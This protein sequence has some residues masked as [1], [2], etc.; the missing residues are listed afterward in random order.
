M[1]HDSKIS[2]R[3]H[4]TRQIYE[5]QTKHSWWSENRRFIAAIRTFYPVFFSLA[6]SDLPKNEGNP[7]SRSEV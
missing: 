5:N 6:V 3:N 7:V 1:I 4:Q 2:D